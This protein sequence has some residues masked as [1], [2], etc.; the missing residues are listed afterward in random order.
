MICTMVLVFPGLNFVLYECMSYLSSVSLY[1]CP[2][3]GVP[4]ATDGMKCLLRTW[5]PFLG[6]HSYRSKLALTVQLMNVAYLNT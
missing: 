6:V 5:C 3:V 4:T 2:W 1:T